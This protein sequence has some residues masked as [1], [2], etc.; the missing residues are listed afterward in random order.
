MP[1]NAPKKYWDLYDRADLEFPA[2]RE[3]PKGSPGYALANV[4]NGELHAYSDITR[5]AT[6]SNE[7]G[8]E[9]IHGYH[10]CVSYVDAQIGKLLATLEEEGLADNTIVVLFSDHGWKLGE[11]NAWSKHTNYEID[12]RVPLLIRVPG[13]KGGVTSNAIVELVDVFPTLCELTGIKAPTNLEGVSLVPV[14][15]NN[16]TT[17]KEAG[18]SQFLRGSKHG[19]SIKTKNFRYTEWFDKKAN[20]VVAKELFDHRND[21]AETRNVV[22]NAQYQ[23]ELK[24]LETLLHSY[25]EK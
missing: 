17:V 21:A 23:K 20:K 2:Y 8:K 11:Y 14:L 5:E 10:A 22:K 7:K 3:V 24:K 9:L 1:F 12:A 15:N 19:V 25:S 16:T 13:K 18:F 4:T 6:V